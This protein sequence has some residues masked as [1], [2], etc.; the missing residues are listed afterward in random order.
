MNGS[1]FTPMLQ[2]LGSLCMVQHVFQVAWPPLFR[3]VTI[4]NCREEA[5][6]EGAT[7]DG[8]QM[9]HY[10]T[11]LQFYCNTSHLTAAA[12]YS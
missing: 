1:T 3:S 2:R 12:A 6:M 5:N 7:D 8:P 9:H 10:A 4:L 11:L